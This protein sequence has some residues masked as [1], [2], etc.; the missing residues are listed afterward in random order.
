M[1]LREAASG[2]L[3]NA[4]ALIAATAVIVNGVLVHCDPNF[5]RI[6]AKNLAPLR[7]H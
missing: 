3:P 6:P 1:D 2:R 5:D 7:L 4:D